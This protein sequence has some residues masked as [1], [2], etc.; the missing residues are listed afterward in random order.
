M[1]ALLRSSLVCLLSSSMLVA[2]STSTSQSAASTQ[3]K[4]RKTTTRRTAKP[5]AATDSS[6]AEQL[7]ELRD[8]LRSQQQQIQQ[9]QNQLATRD[10][11]VRQAQQAASD[12]AAKATDAAA[13]A[14]EAASSVGDSK[15]QVASL[16]DT[17]SALKAND[18]NL[19]ETIQ[20]EQKRVN[21][22]TE[23][24]AT[25]HFKGITIS[26]TGSF[27][28]AAT[29][30]RQRGQGADINTQFSTIPFSAA[31]NGRLSEFNATGRQSRLA[32][33]GEGR[34]GSWVARAYYEADWL[35]A[36]VTSNDNQSNSY[37]MRQRQ[38]YGQIEGDNGWTFTGGQMWSLATETRTGLSNKTEVLPQTIDPQY[39]AGFTWARQYGA[40]VTKSFN[41]KF[42]LGASLEE[43]QTLNVGGG[44]A[45]V[46]STYQQVGNTGGLYNN[47]ANYSYNLAPDLVFK[48]AAEPGWGHYEIFGI[49][50]FFRNRVYP[51]SN[52]TTATGAGAF[53]DN[54]SVGGVGGN[55][56]LPVLKNKKLDLA[57]HALAGDGVGR[58][59]NTGL[60]DVTLR[61]DGTLSPIR[62][63]NALGGLELHATPKLDIYAYYGGDYAERQIY[64]ISP[65]KFSGYGRPTNNTSGCSIEV[66][67][68]GGPGNQILASATATPANC[69]PDNRAVQEGSVGYWYD[70]YRG[71][72]GRIRQSLQYSYFVRNTWAGTGGSPKAVDNMVWT[73]FRYYL[74]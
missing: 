3:S 32:L 64:T 36:G 11:Q 45:L 12:A 35:S 48:A 27:I 66:P 69:S 39:H 60:A 16:T 43:P 28:E 65:G 58:Y 55:L 62:S 31:S 8:M 9:L 54:R 24:P 42:W 25:I 63:G 67:P 14:T 4:T 33:T 30:W 44:G 7:K 68:T 29:V 52:A 61:P 40:R 38:L 22:A 2:Q 17:V 13:K 1:K 21:D 51:N 46:T 57:F 59:T 20:S 37:T 49:A 34:V 53:N 72:K 50:R 10:Q 70:F 74:P 15:T 26:P 73:A 41:K 23:S 56:R 5:A 19:T 18:Q 47:Q 71:P 6:T